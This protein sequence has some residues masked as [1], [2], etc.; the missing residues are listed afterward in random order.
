MIRYNKY[1]PGDIV[2]ELI[3]QYKFS[4][5]M[6]NGKTRSKWHCLCSCGNEADIIETNLVST[7]SCGHL[8]KEFY[9]NRKYE[10]LTGQEFGYLTVK[11]RAK[12]RIGV[13]GRKITRWLCECICG[14]EIVADA[15]ELKRGTVLSCGC[16]RFEK[17]REKYDLTGK[18]MNSIFVKERLDPVKYTGRS[19]YAKYKCIC[20]ECGAEFDVFASALRRGQIS[21]GCINS[22]GEYEIGKLLKSYNIHFE[23]S[24]SFN[25]LLSPFGWPIFF[26]FALRDDN[27]KINLIE[28]QGIQHFIP[29]PDHFGDYQ[30]EITDPLKKEYCKQNNIRLFEIT[31]EDDI[32]SSLDKILS[33]L[34]AN[35]VPSSDNTEKV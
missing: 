7:K 16:K 22:K 28:F 14:K 27:N 31:Y 32:K 2:G 19:S 24:Y 5:R 29:Q 11:E 8:V 13:S 23:T 1:K 10:D 12:S 21:C 17:Q 4:S 6:P 35:F 3:L 15:R 25:D 30:R 34:Y 20:L 26:D 18:I 33:E 9:N